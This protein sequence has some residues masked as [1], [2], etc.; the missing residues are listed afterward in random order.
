MKF[1]KKCIKLLERESYFPLLHSAALLLHSR[2]NLQFPAVSP[3][4]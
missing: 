2:L 4:F 3:F 1:E